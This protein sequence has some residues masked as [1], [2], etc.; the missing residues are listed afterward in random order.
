MQSTHQDKVERVMSLEEVEQLKTR[1]GDMLKH[2]GKVVSI[3][4]DGGCQWDVLMEVP[5]NTTLSSVWSWGKESDLRVGGWSIDSE[6]WD[7]KSQNLINIS[8]VCGENDCDW[9]CD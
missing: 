2:R 8:F 4:S 9:C 5:S 7:S 3:E 6:N 1:I